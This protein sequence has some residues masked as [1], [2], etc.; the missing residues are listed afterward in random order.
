MKFL[1]AIVVTL[2]CISC[3]QRIYIVRHAEKE[4]ATTMTTDVPLTK[5]GAARAQK[6]KEILQSKKI[7]NVY[8]TNTI[9]TKSTAQ[10]TADQFGLSVATYGPRP[11]SAFIAKLKSLKGNTLI[12]GHSNT[13]DDIVNLLTVQNK[14]KDLDDSEYNKLYIVRMKNGKAHF[15][16]KSIY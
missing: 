13:V 16:E 5:E 11:D 14:L 7:K 4:A 8:S 6:V 12:V 9:R 2:F 10:P 3:S 1:L 15:E